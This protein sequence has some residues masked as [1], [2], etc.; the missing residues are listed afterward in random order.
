MNES[1]PSGERRSGSRV[2]VSSLN[3][4]F[5]GS[6]EEDHSLFEY[7]LLEIS[8]CVGSAGIRIAIPGWGVC[9][10][11]LIAGDAVDFHIPFQLGP[12]SFHLGRVVWERWD[13]SLGVQL[14]GARLEKKARMAHPFH[15]SLGNAAIGVDLRGFSS[16]H[17]LLLRVLKDSVLLKKGVLIYLKHLVPLFSRIAGYPHKE[18]PELKRCLLEDIRLKIEEN[19]KALENIFSC[20]QK[21]P[22]KSDELA[23]HL[24]L[25][26]LRSATESEIYPEIFNIAFETGA[27]ISYIGA[28]KTLEKK[29]YYNYNVVVMM[30][31]KAL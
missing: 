7:L 15:I 2:E 22:C 12:E 13:D 5:L 11:Y 9:K 4:P 3:L 25:N 23:R 21:G 20:F 26:A 30:Y 28:I 29:L 17:G 6:R 27:H 18:F 31:L 1:A 10:E 24:D 8:S 14:C 16:T 19:K